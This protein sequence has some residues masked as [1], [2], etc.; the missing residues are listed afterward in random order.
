[1]IL[2]CATTNA[3]KLREFRLA[4]TAT[5]T[6]EP[7]PGLEAA[8]SPEE[9]GTTFE[10]NAIIK[11]RAY[12]AFTDGWLFAE[13]SGLEVDALHGE[14]GVYSARYSGSDATD[15]SNNRLVLDRLGNNPDRR[16]RFVCVIA[17]VTNRGTELVRT[18]RATVEGSILHHPRGSNG[19][20]YDPI[21]W[22]EPFGCSFG[23]VERELKQSV[24]HRGAAL[25]QLM[26]WVDSTLPD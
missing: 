19:F 24:S 12:G 18:F 13:D 11:A 22:Y 1:M 6:I 14:P 26:Q 7:V 10:E 23:E 15:E 21:F 25:R 4:A 17:L 2:Y 8:V 5:C 20:G 3:G 16:A 9:T